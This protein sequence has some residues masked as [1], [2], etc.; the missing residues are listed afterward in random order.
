MSFAFH[1]DAKDGDTITLAN[2]V[3]YQYQEAKKRWMVHSLHDADACPRFEA[4]AVEW[5]DSS[6]PGEQITIEW[7]AYG[8]QAGQQGFSEVRLCNFFGE[9]DVSGGWISI[10]GNK[11]MVYREHTVS[12]DPVYQLLSSEGDLRHYL[13]KT[14]E[15][16]ACEDGE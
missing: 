7:F 13:G 14:V 8:Q 12:G 3:R 16:H 1:K 4:L 6:N 9:I 2:G 10:D 15:V 11:H 5:K